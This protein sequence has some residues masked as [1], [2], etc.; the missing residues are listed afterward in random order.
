MKALVDARAQGQK[1]GTSDE[2][3]FSTVDPDEARSV[4]GKTYYD[5]SIDRLDSGQ[6]FSAAFDVVRLGPLTVGE[7]GFGADVRVRFGDLG[8]HQVDIPLS[9][10]MAW[11]QS[12]MVPVVTAP[13]RAAVF[14]PHGRTVLERLE[15]GRMLA[16]KIEP[17][18]LARHLEGMLGTPVRA[19]FHLGP[20][21]DVASGAGRS[22]ARLVKMVMSEA[23]DAGSLL[24]QPLL[25]VQMQ[26]AL[27]T[28]LLLATDHPYRHALDRPPARGEAQRPVRQV[29]DAVRARPEHPFTAAELARVAQVS[30]RWL[31]E[32]FR[33]QVGMSPMAYLREVRMERVRAELTEADPAHTT[34]GDIA[35]RWGFS[36]L[37]RFAQ[38]YRARFGELP[39][40]TLAS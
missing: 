40:Q 12:G 13:G 11:R 7:V 31:Q 22:W 36:H 9:G 4:L 3:S 6:A 16:V 35:Y 29:M 14:R 2:V 17:R 23:G 8:A 19:G 26:E 18:L 37:G 5:N 25:A 20:S 21:M 27:L 33:R 1:A 10:G 34:V 32:C 24:R 15:R 30:E 39:S 38:H 28:G